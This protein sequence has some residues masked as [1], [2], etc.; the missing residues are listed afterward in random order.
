MYTI[1]W[2]VPVE[3]AVDFSFWARH[4]S[5]LVLLTDKL[6]FESQISWFLKWISTGISGFSHCVPTAFC[7]CSSA[8]VSVYVTSHLF[9]PT[10]CSMLEIEMFSIVT[11]G[12]PIT[13]VKCQISYRPSIKLDL[14]EPLISA[15]QVLSQEKGMPW[16]Q[17]YTSTSSDLPD[18]KLGSIIN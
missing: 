15:C 17:H 18:L 8:L 3:G 10:D 5:F 1:I 13:P 16:C 4:T 7:G 2:F 6:P 11:C 14:P 12:F 9:S